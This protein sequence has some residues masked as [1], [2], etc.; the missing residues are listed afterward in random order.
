MNEDGVMIAYLPEN[1]AWCK[2]D[3]PHMTLVYAGTLDEFD[4]SDLNALGKDAITAARITGPFSLP[5]VSVE[6]LGE[7]IDAVDTLV[8]YPTP[9]LLVARSMV[10]HWNKSKFTEYKPHATIGPAGSAYSD[11]VSYVDDGSDGSEYRSYDRN[12]KAES[13]PDRL[14]FNRIAVVHGNQ[15]LIF[16]TNSF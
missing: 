15:K 12:V 1:G 3:L 14:Y 5:V 16:N 11:K 13:L 2:Q 6:E 7:G 10:M 4:P 9:Q 8:F